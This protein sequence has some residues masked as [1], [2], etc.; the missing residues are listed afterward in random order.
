MFDC[1]PYFLKAVCYAFF[2][3][4]NATSDS[5][6]VSCKD[7]WEQL[8]EACLPKSES[9]TSIDNLLGP[10]LGNNGD[11]TINFNLPSFYFSS[12]SFDYEYLPLRG[13][14]PCYYE[15]VICES[16]PNV[17]GADI[18]GLNENGSYIGGSEVNY[19]CI[20]HSKH[21]V[22]KSTVRCLYSGIWSDPPVCRDRESSS[23]L[24]KILLPTFIF[25]WCLSVV[26]IIIHICNVH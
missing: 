18:E 6:I 7:T 24:L 21:T 1:Y 19:T 23:N 22:G 25:I 11:N 8:T 26:V 5:F 3:R 17:T 14:S 4:C 2:P 9:S 12:N 10:L 20:D 13:D 16:P 15:D